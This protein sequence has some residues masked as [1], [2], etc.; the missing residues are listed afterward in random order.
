MP[1]FLFAVI[2]LIL[3]F[4]LRLSVYVYFD[5]ESKRLS[6]SV[7]LF[8]IIKI[9]GGF[10][11]KYGGDIIIHYSNKRARLFN[12][13]DM[14]KFKLKSGDKK[15][16]EVLSSCL[17]TSFPFTP[18]YCNLAGVITV[19]SN[20]LCP[21]ITTEKDFLK[22][23]S[24]IYLGKDDYLKIYYRLKFMTTLFSGIVLFIKTAVRNEK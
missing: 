9:V 10:I 2:I 8:K 19:A 11:E 1:V 18:E 16:F 3:F 6:F 12:K 20:L 17:V 5:G 21:F 15:H 24:I 14:G 23:K 7:Y 13:S 22:I 4:P